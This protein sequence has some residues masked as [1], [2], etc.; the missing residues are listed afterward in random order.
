MKVQEERAFQSEQITSEKIGKKYICLGS[1]WKGILMINNEVEEAGRD[2]IIQ[3][4]SVL[5][6]HWEFIL[7]MR[8]SHRRGLKQESDVI[9]FLF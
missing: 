1:R 3:D 7:R 8:R 6:G 4:H 5:A 2:Q 9:R